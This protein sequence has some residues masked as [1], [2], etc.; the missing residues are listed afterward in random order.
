MAFPAYS[1]PYV[2][3]IEPK[4][5]SVDVDISQDI[6]I[7]FSDDLD[8]N[9]IN[10]RN[11]TL[12]NE[13]GIIPGRFNYD[14]EKKTVVFIPDE[15]LKYNTE[16]TIRISSSIRN[17]TGQNLEKDY[18]FFFRTTDLVL[19]E[20]PVIIH[21]A[22]QSIINS[23]KIIWKKAE[24]AEAYHIEIARDKR[25]TNLVYS[26]N[27]LNDYQLVIDS[28]SDHAGITVDGLEYNQ[29]YFVRVRALDIVYDTA[30]AVVELNK[31][32]IYFH[33]NNRRRI[34]L[35]QKYTPIEGINSFIVYDMAGNR[36]ELNEGKYIIEPNKR[37]ISFDADGIDIGRVVIDLIYGIK[38]DDS[39]WSEIHS[40]YYER[41]RSEEIDFKSLILTTLSSNRAGEIELIQP[42]EMINIEPGIDEIRF[43]IY[44]NVNPEDVSVS[45]TGYSLNDI[46]YIRSHGQVKGELNVVEVLEDH[47]VFSYSIPRLLENNEYV[48]K[49]R[50]KNNETRF[51]FLS[52][53]TPAF[54]TVRSIRSSGIGSFLNSMPDKIILFNIYDNSVMAVDIAETHNNAF[55]INNPPLAAIKYT[56][57]KT[58]LDLLYA[59]Y[60]EKTSSKSTTLGDFA[61]NA[62]KYDEI[63][64]ILD[65]L[66]KE[67]EYWEQLLKGSTSVFAQPVSVQKAEGSYLLNSRIW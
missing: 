40:F 48:L 63:K 52:K 28:D 22:N 62:F 41:P 33:T 31:N 44:G 15:P 53:V 21:P 25:F 35:E 51:K 67:L 32:S 36:Y 17:I 19:L 18:I 5:K 49:V 30:S 7:I 66:R 26:N 12:Y 27:F 13:N 34:L 1:N 60:L 59:I 4:N 56:F 45:L 37:E 55:D 14:N 16:Y 20:P 8:Q 24:Y 47:T 3:D 2:V 43:R 46:P 9:Y 57:I 61:I 6:K 64:P 38:K 50:Y 54:C 11:I 23:P 42:E 29:E 65:D 39:V 58:Q 10:S